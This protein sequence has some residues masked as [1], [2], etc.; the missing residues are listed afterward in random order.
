MKRSLKQSF[1]LFVVSAL[2]NYSH[3]TLSMS[4]EDSINSPMVAHF[5][6]ES[7]CP[8][9]Q[10]VL[11]FELA[12]KSFDELSILF[13]TCLHGIHL[14]CALNYIQ[15]KKES[16]ELRYS[17]CPV[18]RKPLSFSQLERIIPGI[19]A[20]RDQEIAALRNSF[21]DHDFLIAFLLYADQGELGEPD[22]LPF[23]LVN[24][25][26][27]LIADPFESELSD[28]SARSSDSETPPF[29]GDYSDY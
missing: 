10:E 13:N 9:C 28:S 1:L 8:I 22:A 20:C 24:R 6:E 2:L 16:G 27:G 7:V 14:Q 26:G 5:A 4:D 11:S 18:C 23:F 21:A 17:C 29:E 3:H 12:G 19:Q 25:H 15:S